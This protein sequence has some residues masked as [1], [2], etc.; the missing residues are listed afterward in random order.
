MIGNLRDLLL[1]LLFFVVQTDL[2]LKCW[3]NTCPILIILF[4][5]NELKFGNHTR[6][7]LKRDE[8]K[9]WKHT[10]INFI[11]ICHSVICHCIM[12]DII[13]YP[14]NCC[15][16][17]IYML[18]IIIIQYIFDFTGFYWIRYWNVIYWKKYNFNK[19]KWHSLYYNDWI[20]W[21]L[22]R[23]I[24]LNEMRKVINI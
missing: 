20:L 2:S 3:S 24:S 18:R 17:K 14:T 6:S 19:D 1:V 4:A 13:W 15:C 9:T 12:L 5:W 21:Y 22:Q 10:L 16:I 23:C 7:R 11:T 8:T